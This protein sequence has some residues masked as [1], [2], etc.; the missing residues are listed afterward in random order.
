MILTTDVILKSR[1]ASVLFAIILRCFANVLIHFPN[2]YH[3]INGLNKEVYTCV[4]TFLSWLQQW[5]IYSGFSLR[6]LVTV[7]G[8]GLLA[9]EFCVVNGEFSDLWCLMNTLYTC[10]ALFL[11]HKPRTPVKGLL[12][13]W[14]IGQTTG[15]HFFFI[16]PIDWKRTWKKSGLSRI[17]AMT[18]HSIFNP[19]IK[20]L[21]RLYSVLVISLEKLLTFKRKFFSQV[22][23]I[24]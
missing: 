12:E 8:Y 7:I 10:I 17:L 23:F 20:Q 15:H 5:G 18:K 22:S 13:K 2:F 14:Q 1:F 24:V 9:G 11:F 19:E 21:I 4:S 6:I 16:N 3:L